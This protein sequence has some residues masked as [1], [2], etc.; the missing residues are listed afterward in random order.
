[1]CRARPPA[2]RG[3]RHPGDAARARGEPAHGGALPAPPLH[4]D[5]APLGRVLPRLP[6]GRRAPRG[7]HLSRGRGGGGGRDLAGAGGG[8]LPPGAPPGRLRRGRARGG[9]VRIRRRGWTHRAVRALQIGGALVVALSGL[10]AGY[11]KVMAS[12][13]LRVARVEVR[14]GHFLSEGEVRELLGPAVGENILN[15]DIE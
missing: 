5:A 4:A 9:R 12:E 7:R 15:L 2:H 10:W 8:D 13:R 11:A 3:P 1:V 6:P 14:G